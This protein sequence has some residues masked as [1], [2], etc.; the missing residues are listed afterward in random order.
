MIF[1][2]IK[3]KDMRILYEYIVLIKGIKGHIDAHYITQVYV[4]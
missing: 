1:F 3:L 4:F 2:M